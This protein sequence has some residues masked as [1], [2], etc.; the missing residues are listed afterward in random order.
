MRRLFGLW[1]WMGRVLEECDR[2]APDLA[3]EA[4]HDLRIALRRC[5]TMADAFMLIDPCKT[6]KSMKREGG[7]LFKQLGEL[8]DVQVMMEWVQRLGTSADPG[9]ARMLEHLAPR[10]T[11]L[12]QDTL[13]ALRAFDRNRWGD[14]R[15]RLQRRSRRIPLEGRVYQLNALRAWDEAYRL[16]R[17]AL[18]NRSIR[19]WHALRVG[20]KK[21]RYTVE[22]FLPARH[23]RWGQDLKN[24]QDWLGEIHDL[25]VLWDTAVRIN[26]FPTAESRMQWRASIDREKEER[27][28]RYREKTLGPLSLWNVW[29]SGLPLPERLFQAALQWLQT[30]AYFRDA[31]LVAA[32]RTRRLALQLFNGLNVPG[33]AGR[34]EIRDQRN[35]LH[36]AAIFHE[37][38]GTAS[39]KKHGK[40][41][42]RLLCELP[43]LPGFSTEFVSR[44]AIVVRH[45]AGGLAI[46]EDRALARFEEC[47]RESIIRLTGI[48][49]LAEALALYFDPPLARISVHREPG[50]ILVNAD[51]HPGSSR[52]AEK[53]ARARYLLEVACNQPVFVRSADASPETGK[54]L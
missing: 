42:A 34:N 3:P 52:Q 28:R 5:R 12:K 9:A 19:S 48:L 36:A 49:R 41:S 22:N 13:S 23:E 46:L 45:H 54:S 1:Y 40:R 44:C 17:E 43:P 39:R 35:I 7:R 27:I 33:S 6:W 30:A 31:D 24:M 51:G 50:S 16:H 32:R 18:R 26:A 21:F 37:V 10:E 38:G 47:E 20:L 53:L 14:W 29:R 2:A 15:G 25:A 11:Q 8:R 4:V